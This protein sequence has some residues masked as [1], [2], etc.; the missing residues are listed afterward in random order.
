MYLNVCSRAPE[1]CSRSLVISGLIKTHVSWLTILIQVLAGCFFLSQYGYLPVLSYG[2]LFFSLEG[3]NLFFLKKAKIRYFVIQ[4]KKRCFSNCVQN[5]PSS[6]QLKSQLGPTKY[7]FKD[8]LVG[9]YFFPAKI[10]YNFL[11]HSVKGD[12]VFSVI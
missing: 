5:C 9:W 12:A 6:L 4:E 1:I 7:S 11:Q 2:Y 3:R 10:F 8:L